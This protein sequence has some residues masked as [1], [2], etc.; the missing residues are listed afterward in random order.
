MRK[1]FPGYYQLSEEEYKEL[2]EKCHF[3]LDANILLNLFRFSKTT[4]EE[5]FAV[6]DKIKPRLWL[7]YTAAEEYHRNLL[8]TI[9]AQQEEATPERALKE[10]DSFIKKNFP[11]SKQH[12]FLNISEIT[13]TLNSTYEKLKKHY[14]SQEDLKAYEQEC[15]SILRRV[16]DLFEGR[17]GDEMSADELSKKYKEIDERYDAKRPPGYKDTSDK[18]GK[19]RYGDALIWLELLE[20]AK[21]N[22]VPIIFV[23]DDGKEDWWQISRN[24]K[25]VG[26][27]PELIAEMQKYAGC[28]FLM[29]SSKQFLGWAARMLNI[30][31]TNLDSALEEVQSV[32]DEGLKFWNYVS[33]GSL[34]SNLQELLKKNPSLQELL[35]KNQVWDCTSYWGTAQVFS[36]DEAAA[37]KSG[38]IKTLSYIADLLKIDPNQEPQIMVKQILDR[39]ILGIEERNTLISA[40]QKL[41]L[42]EAG[43]QK[44]PKNDPHVSRVGSMLFDVFWQLQKGEF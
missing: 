26:P 30:A 1:K 35:E 33:S 42:A 6:F 7:S 22:K 16:S 24:N 36:P 28:R 18:K 11:A 29:Y 4:R 43:I 40:L 14:E 3:S 39:Q 9:T 27:R 17:V 13:E 23:T 21:A 37:L 25:T 38:L 10:L 34:Q 32:Q 31:S 2:W 20:H 19:E 5:F 8:E 15:D 44:I 12:A 41:H